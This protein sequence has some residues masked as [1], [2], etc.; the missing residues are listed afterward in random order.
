MV[1]GSPT[2]VG[3]THWRDP[4]ARARL[5]GVFL[6]FYDQLDAPAREAYWKRWGAPQAWWTSFL[7]PDLDALFADEDAAPAARNFR[8]EWLG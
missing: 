5:Q 1:S 3:N 6:S 8:E 7:H 4:D 2:P